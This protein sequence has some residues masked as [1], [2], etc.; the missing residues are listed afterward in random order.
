[1]I[2]Y[3][4]TGPLVIKLQANVVILVTFI[5]GQERNTILAPVE[6]TALAVWPLLPADV[7]PLGL[8]VGE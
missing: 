1:V 3:D 4:P 7:S 5:S 2:F 8:A 6:A